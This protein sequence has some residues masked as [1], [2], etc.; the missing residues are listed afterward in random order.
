MAKKI[1]VSDQQYDA[2]IQSPRKFFEV[3]NVAYISRKGK[4]GKKKKYGG[5]FLDGSMSEPPMYFLREEAENELNQLQ[6]ENPSDQFELRC[7]WV[8]VRGKA[9]FT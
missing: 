5:Y 9:Y 1:V 8:I 2:V 7:R 4:S 6:L 3:V